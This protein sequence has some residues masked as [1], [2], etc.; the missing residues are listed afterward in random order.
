MGRVGM[1]P[2]IS[3][4]EDK[5]QTCH[6]LQ[7]GHQLQLEKY[8]LTVSGPIKQSVTLLWCSSLVSENLCIII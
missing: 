6:H 3:G 5:P 1:S 7:S 2:Q 4:S 8:E